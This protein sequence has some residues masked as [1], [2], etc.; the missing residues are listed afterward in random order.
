MWFMNQMGD[1][2]RKQRQILAKSIS[3]IEYPSWRIQ[4]TIGPEELR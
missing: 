2:N 4:P 1:T 3:D